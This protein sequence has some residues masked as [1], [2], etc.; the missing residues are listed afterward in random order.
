MKG[1]SLDAIAPKRVEALSRRL[2]DE[3][4]V[5]DAR[6]YRGHCL[7]QTAA[8]VWTACDGRTTVME[9]TRDLQQK[10][11]SGI[12][13]RVVSMALLKLERAGLLLEG[14][15]V[16]DEL[17]AMSRREAMRK[18]GIAG[19]VALPVITSILVPTP[20]HALSCFPLGH[21]CAVNAEC[22]SN[23]CGAGLLCL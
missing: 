4:L 10:L 6:T 21:A 7:N 12:D 15:C 19:A 17:R 20:A 13:E 14:T 5:Y 16:P 22:C 18:I 2:G 1:R 23:I 11:K 9:I 8:A 3:L